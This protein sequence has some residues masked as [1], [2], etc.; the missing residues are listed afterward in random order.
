MADML[1]EKFKILNADLKVWNKEEFENRD[2]RIGTLVE[3]IKEF[4]LKV[5]DG[6]LSFGDVQARSKRGNSMICGS[7]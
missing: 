4:D 3:E 7:Y 2:R 5:K 6:A 1:K